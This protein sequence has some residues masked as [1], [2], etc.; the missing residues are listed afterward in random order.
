[1]FAD[2]S[3]KHTLYNYLKGGCGK[4]GTLLCSQV[5]GNRA[6]GNGLKLHQGRTRLDIRKN[7]FF[8]KSGQILEQVAQRSGG[9]TVPGAV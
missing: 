1:M 7:F 3:R 5:T 8:L 2:P 9:V 6:R 4:V